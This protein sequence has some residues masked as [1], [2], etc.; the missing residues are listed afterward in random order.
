MSEDMNPDP[1]QQWC[2]L[3]SPPTPPPAK[4]EKPADTLKVQ[5]IGNKYSTLSLVVRQQ[6]ADEAEIEEGSS[7]QYMLQAIHTLTE[8]ISIAVS[9]KQ[10]V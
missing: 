3:P 5:D 6:E 7:L 10:W 9:S 4:A 8:A 1:P 2:D